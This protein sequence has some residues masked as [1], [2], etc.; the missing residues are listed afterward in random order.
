MINNNTFQTHLAR[1]NHR[2]DYIIN[3]TKKTMQN[4][5]GKIKA[6]HIK[7]GKREQKEK[8]KKHK[9]TETKFRFDEYK[10]E[11]EEDTKENHDGC[12]DYG[13]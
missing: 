13:A 1:R 12:M 4:L 8:T 7:Q 3:T 2:V 11:A 9:N 6:I 10:R 5:Y